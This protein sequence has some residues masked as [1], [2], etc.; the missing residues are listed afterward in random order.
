MKT[1]TLKLKAT[2]ITL[3]LSCATPAITEA[4]TPASQAIIQTV[5][6]GGTN[7]K[8]QLDL[9]TCTEN[10]FFEWMLQETDAAFKKI[11]ER[12]EAFIDQKNKQSYDAYIAS[13]DQ[14][15]AD[16]FANL[17]TPLKQKLDIAKATQPGSDFQKLLEKTYKVAEEMAYN[18]LKKLIGVLKDH[19][20]SPDAKKA[21]ALVGKLK[22]L[23]TRLT[24]V[25][26][27]DD[28]EQKIVEVCKYLPK[29]VTPKVTQEIDRIKQL[30]K[31]LKAK[32]AATQ[33]KVN[34]EL[35]NVISAMLKRI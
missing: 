11:R 18:E 4:A 30:V 17:M 6:N 1:D 12:V 16:I 10:E 22:P 28:L 34:L 31:E 2:V 5:I 27:F 29:N 24:S 7:Q 3:A 13:L 25:A 15:E 26:T 23:L 9:A 20:K 19:R 32:S 35:F 8:R 14:L 33:G 21:T